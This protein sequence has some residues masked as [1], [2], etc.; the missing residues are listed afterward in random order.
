MSYTP[1]KMIKRLSLTGVTSLSCLL[2]WPALVYAQEQKILSRVE[3]IQQEMIAQDPLNN[4]LNEVTQMKEEFQNGYGD[5]APEIAAIVRTLKNPFIP[6]LPIEEPET[7]AP[8]PPKI[9]ASTPPLARPNNPRQQTDRRLPVEQAKE[10]SPQVTVSGMVWN[11]DR[12]QAIVNGRVVT[13]GDTIESWTITH[14]D[15]T[16][17]EV[18]LQDRKLVFKP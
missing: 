7:Q 14:I 9:D 4:I 13:I 1:R 15:Q 18:S 17:V 6:Q 10:P 8:Q 11:S 16:G 3:N 2:L 12:P 5:V